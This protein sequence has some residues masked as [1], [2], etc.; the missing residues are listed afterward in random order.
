MTDRHMLLEWQIF[1]LH[2]KSF[3]KLVAFDL[4]MVSHSALV[5]DIIA[6]FKSEIDFF[7]IF[8]NTTFDISAKKVENNKAS[9]SNYQT[10]IAS[11]SIGL[12]FK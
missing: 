12:S 10:S 8:Y 3:D 5:S 6:C 2:N 9:T 11:M 4:Q 7:C 1:N